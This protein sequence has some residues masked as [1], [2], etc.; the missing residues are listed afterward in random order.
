[1]RFEGFGIFGFGFHCFRSSDLPSLR[2]AGMP[3]DTPENCTTFNY[4]NPT[5]RYSGNLERE[6]TH[7]HAVSAN[8]ETGA[9]RATHHT[10][11]TA[12]IV[13]M[14][15]MMATMIR[16]LNDVDDGGGALMMLLMTM[17]MMPMVMIMMTKRM[18]AMMAT[19]TMTMLGG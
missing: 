4:F 8:Q 19:K 12:K 13:M 16:R 11:L 1:M 14:L 18:V 5:V 6:S 3:L 10:P 15:T 9:Q 7:S 17:T 2:A